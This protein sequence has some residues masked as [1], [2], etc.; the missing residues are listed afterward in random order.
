MMVFPPSPQSLVAAAL[1]LAAGLA[2]ALAAPP[3]PAPAA[4]P[5]AWTERLERASDLQR[6]GAD[7]KAAAER[8]YEQSYN[9]CYRKF[10]VY[11]CWD[12]AHETYVEAV[13]VARRL[14]NEGKAIER[15]V[16]KEQRSE[17]E[18]RF[19]A[20]E[21]E[22]AEKLRT[23]AADTA[24][25]RQAAAEAEAATRADKA[26]KAEE[27]AQR[28]AEDAERQ[29]KKRED[30]DRRVAEQMQKAAAKPVRPASP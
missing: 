21:E 20:E 14:E 26:K 10:M 17:R 28:R 9:D 16:Q 22:R 15:Q 6:R 29:R 7:D 12:K 2:P 18:L 13:S 8:N 30:H 19:A 25:A 3:D 24:A 1:C 5:L 4:D 27:G 11:R 23:L